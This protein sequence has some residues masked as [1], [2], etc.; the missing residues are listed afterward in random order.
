MRRIAIIVALIAIL[1]LGLFWFTRPQPIPVALKEVAAGKVEATLANTRAG[2]VEACQRTKLSTIIGGRIE[3]LGVK[4]GDRVKKGQLLLKLWNDD[5]QAQSALAQ[6]QITLSA[7]RSEEACIAAVN[8]EKEAARQSELRAKGFVSS[9][10]EEAARTDA[11]V[12]RASCNTAKADIAQAEAKLKTTRVDQGRV[13]LYAPF[14][15]TIAKIVGELGE[16]STP[17]PPGVPTPPAIDLI[18]DS[19]LYIKAPMDE[20][21]APKIQTG[22][23]VRITLDALPGKVLP[24]KVRRVAPYV[25]AVE[26]Q[27]RTVDIEV[28]FDQPETAGK[29]LVGYSADVEIILSG[30]DNVLR[31]PTA[32]IQ[33]GGKVLL[34]NPESGKLEER[35]IKAGLAN[36][37]YTEVMEGLKA[38][39]RIVTSLDKEGVKAGAKVTPDDKAKAK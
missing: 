23:P 30:R 8:A 24:G 31:I 36:W 33:E 29:L 9:S 27:A 17:S 3:Y 39:E 16:Y 38:G 14:D 1:G 18:D 7:K 19:C 22:Q 32:A 6:A 15:G 21:D 4:E 11:E 20:V 5:Q 26:K 37:E 13:A 35:Q 28:D 25:S 2:T 34:F 12:R 10:R